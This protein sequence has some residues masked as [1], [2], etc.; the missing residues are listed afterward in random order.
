MRER[1]T[2]RPGNVD[3]RPGSPTG[4]FIS[5]RESLVERSEKRNEA[6]AS[7]KIPLLKRNKAPEARRG[8]SLAG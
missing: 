6:S 3:R 1:K 5:L 4:D 7:G 2:P 8:Q